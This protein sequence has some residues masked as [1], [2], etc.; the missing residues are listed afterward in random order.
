MMQQKIESNQY[1]RINH[2][3]NIMQQLHGR[4]KPNIPDNVRQKINKEL[5]GKKNLTKY[6]VILAMKRLNYRQ[7]Y[8]YADLFIQQPV[9]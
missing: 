7:Y 9:D 6:D 8:E 1:Y 2:L 3:V 5:A 4:E